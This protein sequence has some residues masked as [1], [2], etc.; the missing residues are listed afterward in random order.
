MCVDRPAPRRAGSC[1]CCSDLVETNYTKP[2]RESPC[3]HAHH[4]VVR[5][6]TAEPCP[7]SGRHLLWLRREVKAC[8]WYRIG[9]G[10]SQGD[11]LAEDKDTSGPDGVVG[12]GSGTVRL[13][14][15]VLWGSPVTLGRV[16]GLSTMWLRVARTHRMDVEPPG[17]GVESSRVEGGQGDGGAGSPHPGLWGPARLLPSHPGRCQLSL[18]GWAE[19]ED[20]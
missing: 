13:G 7:R 19:S 20:V 6:S 15:H 9:I 12:F 17:H 4:R 3:K 14:A 10:G 16:L 1:C 11:R 18:Q 5:D 8:P 2:E